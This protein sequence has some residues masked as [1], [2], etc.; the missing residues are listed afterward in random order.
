M[1][2]ELVDPTRLSG[3]TFLVDDPTTTVGAR[4]APAGVARVHGEVEPIVALEPDLVI[5]AGFTAADVVVELLAAGLP[6]VR[7]DEH[8][9]FEGIERDLE[10]LGR[11][12]GEQGRGQSMV[13]DL[14]ARL[15]AVAAEPAPIPAPRVL[16]WSHGSTAGQHT[17]LDECIRRA[18]GVNVAAEAG[19]Q[20]R[21]PIGIEFALSTEPDI[22]IV[23]VTGQTTRS[24]APE[25]LSPKEHWQA[26][27][28]YRRGNVFGIPSAWL[29]S[30]SQRAVL[31][32]EALASILHGRPS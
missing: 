16:Y 6:V 19:L 24:H 12:T 22:V 3:L 1:L 17:L 18:G 29:S 4:R 5:V 23:S 13:A 14:R 2:L 31:A 11:A 10:K 7:L 32:L 27:A 20:G 8:D 9:S 25:L 26:L 30:V 15:A 21:V 28:A